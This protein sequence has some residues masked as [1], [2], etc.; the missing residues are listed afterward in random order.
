MSGGVDSSVAALLLKEQGYDVIGITLKLSS[1]DVCSQ[2][3]QVCC[4]PQDVKD[5]K[6]VA[7]YL[8]IKHYTIDW[9]DLFKRE[10]IQDFV[11]SYSKGLTPNPCVVCNK[12]IKTGR[13]ARYVNLFLGADYLSTG[14]YIRKS[15]IEKFSVLQRGIDPKKDQSYFMALLEPSVVDLL[16]FPLGNFTKKQVR[17]IAQKYRLPVSSKK[18]SFEICFTGGKS[19]ADYLNENNLINESSGKIRHISGIN[20]GIHKGLSYYT[21]GQRRGL[22][23]RWEKPLYVID[24][25]T[26]DNTLLVGEEE[27]LLVDKVTAV[28]INLF[29][30]KEKWNLERIYIQGR[31]NQK[32]IPVKS[33]QIDKNKIEIFFVEKQKKFS[34]GQILAVYQEDKLIA[35]G[36][37]V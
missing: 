18:D 19:P 3:L 33:I 9:E 1:I 5:A 35:G 16:L 15:Q 29:V 10:V 12:K 34:P 21:I 22:G 2:D 32:P 30:P 6:Q 27:F 14:H 8:G 28:N 7:S 17:E 36:T 4:S 26:K 31:Y 24:K 23:I 11:D 37:I 25:N 13:L 20:L